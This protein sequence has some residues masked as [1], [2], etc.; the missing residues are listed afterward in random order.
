ML[1]EDPEDASLPPAR[2]SDPKVTAEG[3]RAARM[4]FD[5][6]TSHLVLHHIPDL[7][8]VLKTMLGC[9]KEGGSV[10][11]TDF[12]DEGLHSRAFHP[13]SRMEGVERD[14]IPRVAMEETMKQVG[15]THVKV[16]VGWSMEKRVERWEGEFGSKGRG[17]ETEGEVRMFPFVVCL[18]TR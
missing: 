9:L 18:G 12:E 6:I 5:L 2:D 10:A 8:G 15:F 1:L 14:G 17:A 13:K 3:G 11:L 7:E 4:K 16:E